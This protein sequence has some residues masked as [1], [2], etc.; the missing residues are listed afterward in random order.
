MKLVLKNN[1]NSWI[2]L[3]F[4]LLW[5]CIIH[6]CAKQLKHIIH[7]QQHWQRITDVL[8]KDP[9]KCGITKTESF[10]CLQLE[11]MYCLYLAAGQA[12]I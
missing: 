2:F 4:M 1:K 12:G 8:Q 10:Y 9:G 5:L 6:S 7:H 3:K 11:E